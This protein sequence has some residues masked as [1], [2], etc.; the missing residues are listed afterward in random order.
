MN[1]FR[2]YVIIF[3]RSGSWAEG[4]CIITPKSRRIE[5]AS[6]CFG[7]PRG[8]WRAAL[9]RPPNLLLLAVV[10]SWLFGCSSEHF[11]WP[12]AYRLIRSNQQLPATF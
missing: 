1:S 9:T 11:S 3:G 12:R 6:F 5:I 7:L 8:S 4:S 2:L 10:P